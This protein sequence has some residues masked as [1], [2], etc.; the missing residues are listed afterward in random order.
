MLEEVAHPARTNTHKHFHEVGAANREER[1][2][3]FPGDGLGQQGLAAT[4]RPREQH[5]AGDAS[6]KTSK[7]LGA[8][9]KLHDLVHFVFGFVDAGHVGEGHADGFFG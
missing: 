6:A 4:G 5:A 3:G 8:L 2:V 1:D 7:L 9:Q